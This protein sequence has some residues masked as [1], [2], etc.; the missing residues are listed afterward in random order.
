MYKLVAI[1]LD[2]TLLT[3]Q[4]ELTDGT[5]KALEAAQAKGVTITLAT[6]RMYA[7]ARNVA[8]QIGLRVPLITYQGALVKHSEDGTVFYERYV[9]QEVI[10][11]VFD[12]AAKHDLHLQAYVNDEL[13]A[14][15]ENERLIAYSR[16]SK[17][18]YRIEPDFAKL[19]EYPMHKLLII[20]E[21]D[22]LDQIK[23]EFEQQYGKI[24]H[25]TKSKPNF[26][27]VMHP[28]GTKGHALQHLAAQIGCSIEETIA[29]GDSYNDLE[30]LQTAG[31]G[32]AMGNAVEALKE[33]ADFVTYSNNEEGVRHVIEKFILS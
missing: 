33:A 2:D 24:A 6:G 10:R 31:L 13:I 30:M 7:S 1:D 15:R 28:E 29:I 19:A 12:Y 4:L 26:L 20:D 14:A 27:E 8:R 25:F 23:A 18:P 5:R 17:I 22:I 32:V 16:N 21:P 9:P 11:Y 3:D